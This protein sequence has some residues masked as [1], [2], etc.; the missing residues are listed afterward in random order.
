ERVL[1]EFAEHYH[2]NPKLVPFLVNNIQEQVH[3]YDWVCFDAAWSTALMELRTPG[4]PKFKL[5]AQL[6]AWYVRGIL[7]CKPDLNGRLEVRTRAASNSVFGMAVAEEKLP[8]D[9]A[10]RLEWADG[11]PLTE[12]HPALRGTPVPPR[13]PVQS[14]PVSTL[15]VRDEGQSGLFGEVA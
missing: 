10:Q 4:G 3:K 1:R 13:K 12:P 15:V 6:K 14:V 5:S 8:G 11:S 7:Y 9:Y 2:T